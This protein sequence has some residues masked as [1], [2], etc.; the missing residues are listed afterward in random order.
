M[1]TTT[2][3]IVHKNEDRDIIAGQGSGFCT[4]TIA[5][6]C[7]TTDKHFVIFDG[8][9]LQPQWVRCEK[10]VV[11]VLI[12]D[13]GEVSPLASKAVNVENSVNYQCQLCKITGEEDDLYDGTLLHCRSCQLV[14]HSYCCPGEELTPIKANSKVSEKGWKCWN[15]FGK[16]IFDILKQIL[17]YCNPRYL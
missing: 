12:G 3:R 7:P 2:H 16:T 10:G 15:C 1:R 9:G 11:D 5:S 14:C 13:S 4:G 8:E 17:M 6:Y